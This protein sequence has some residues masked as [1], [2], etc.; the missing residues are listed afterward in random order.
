MNI[1]FLGGDIDRMAE[2]LTEK[3]DFYSRDVVD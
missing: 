3:L 1:T 2:S